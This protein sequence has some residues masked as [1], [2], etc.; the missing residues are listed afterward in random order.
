MMCTVMRRKKLFN[1]FTLTTDEKPM[2]L[3]YSIALASTPFPESRD[4][5]DEF[6]IFEVFEHPINSYC[7]HLQYIC[8]F[9]G[10]VSSLFFCEQMYDFLPCPCYFHEGHYK[11]KNRYCNNIASVRIVIFSIY[12]KSKDENITIH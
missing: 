3:I 2:V 9:V 12:L 11:G 4:M 8:Y 5:M 7:V 1:F 6:F 10:S